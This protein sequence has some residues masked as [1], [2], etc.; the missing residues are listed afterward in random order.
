MGNIL[1]IFR[2]YYKIFLQ[3]KNIYNKIFQKQKIYKHK[4]DKN[5]VDNF[6]IKLV[7]IISKKLIKKKYE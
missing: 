7:I 5:K 1:L 2:I 4:W 6:V 3:K